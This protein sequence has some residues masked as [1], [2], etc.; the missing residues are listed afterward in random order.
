MI[1]SA[2][3]SLD[4]KGESI[5]SRLIARELGIKKSWE[6]LRK[7]MLSEMGG[8]NN[9]I[10]NYKLFLGHLAAK[11]IKFCD[12]SLDLLKKLGWLEGIEY[13]N[14][15]FCKPNTL[16]VSSHTLM[17]N[18]IGFLFSTS[19]TKAKKAHTSGYIGKS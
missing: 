7:Y 14:R 5:T 18:R 17:M 2:V 9:L 11:M 10:G 12:N 6:T 1:A 4:S 3:A 19:F 13:D 8:I 15:H 16:T